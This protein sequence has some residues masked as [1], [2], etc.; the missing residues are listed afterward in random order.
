[1]SD[2][3]PPTAP[4]MSDR[5]P[6]T[7]PTMSDRPPPTAPT[8]PSFQNSMG[9]LRG[10]GDEAVHPPSNKYS[11][12][13]SCQIKL[14]PKGSAAA[15]TL[16]DR[17]RL[18]PG[19][20]GQLLFGEGGSMA[21]GPMWQQPRNAWGE[22]EYIDLGAGK[23]DGESI[24]VH[25]NDR[26]FIV[27]NNK[28]GEMVFDVS[29]W[30]LDAGNHL[31]LVKGVGKRSGETMAHNDNRGRL[32]VQN[33]DGTISPKHATHLVLAAKLPGMTT[34]F[35]GK[36][37]AYDIEG[38]WGCSLCPFVYLSAIEK[39]LARDEDT[40]LHS[41]LCL[42]LF[43]HYNE[44][45]DRV[46][47]SN[48]FKKRGQKDT[49]NYGKPSCLCF[50]AGCSVRF[51]RCCGDGY[52]SRGANKIIPAEDLAGCWGCA[53]FPI[54][55][56]CESKTAVGRDKLIHS[57]VCLPLFIPYSDEWERQ[58]ETNLFKKAKDG[59]QVEYKAPGGSLCLGL[60]CTT[61]FW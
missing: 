18:V 41:G 46:G 58:G 61:K 5:P 35:P 57:G 4:T 14:A 42:P 56:A 50:G 20:K 6:P 3:P 26:G 17:H 34:N 11:S 49:L 27:W 2:R 45:W 40:L 52:D 55:G 25:L 7:A 21:I 24:E 28:F 16:G 37:S 30:K 39:K 59:S 48:V 53:C 33:A 54:F 31:V 19:R 43:L 9:D 12:S 36:I 47:D 38:C 13:S 51:C 8:A 1:M 15:I 32:F 29:M 23:A 60:A 22:W 44:Y 10:P